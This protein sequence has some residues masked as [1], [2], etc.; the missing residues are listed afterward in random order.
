[1]S[2]SE[3]GIFDGM[4]FFNQQTTCSFHKNCLSK[5]FCLTLPVGLF[6][7]CA[8][9]PPEHIKDPGHLTYL[10]FTNREAQCSRCHGDEGIGGM[11]GPKIRGVVQK[12]GREYVKETILY[13]KGEGDN[14]MPA[15]V[16]ELTPGQ[17]D[18]LIRFLTTLSDSLPQNSVS[19]TTNKH[20]Q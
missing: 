7:A 16:D 20:F 19:D 12:K 2:F 6:L 4:K 5:I 3:I 1:M 17:I 8:P 9:Q 14:K 18:Q 13:G 15:F 11:F 10:G